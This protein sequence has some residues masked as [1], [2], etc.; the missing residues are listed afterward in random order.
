M[1]WESGEEGADTAPHNE[2]HS[3]AS[4][5]KTGAAASQSLTGRPS[6]Q[7][8]SCGPLPPWP[9]SSRGQTALWAAEG[10]FLQEYLF[11]TSLLAEESARKSGGCSGKALSRSPL[12]LWELVCLGVLWRGKSPE[13]FWEAMT[14][15]MAQ[16]QGL[17]QWQGDKVELW[18][19][20]S[21]YTCPR[22]SDIPYFLENAVSVTKSIQETSRP[23]YSRVAKGFSLTWFFFVGM[24]PF[25]EH[26][27]SGLKSVSW[28]SLS[29]VFLRVHAFKCYKGQGIVLQHRALA[30]PWHISFWRC[31]SR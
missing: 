19:K 12:E 9:Q 28:A 10:S 30:R 16:L 1:W 17:F 14:V 18:E 23:Y 3:T 2:K 21:R 4:A 11:V 24:K 5:M 27:C 25:C 26:C 15:V 20:C 8:R 13:A 31:K 6:P 29:G 7:P 22:S